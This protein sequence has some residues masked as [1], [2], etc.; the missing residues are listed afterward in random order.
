MTIFDNVILTAHIGASANQSRFL[1][2]LEATKNCI[3]V[4]NGEKVKVIIDPNIINWGVYTESL[5][6][7][8][9]CAVKSKKGIYVFKGE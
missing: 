7:S 1:M 2:E 5:F 3:D 4:L 6:A 9:Y 8:D